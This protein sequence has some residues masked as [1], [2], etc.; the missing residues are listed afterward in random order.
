MFPLSVKTMIPRRTD[1]SIM[2][3]ILFLCDRV[4]HGVAAL[5]PSL[6]RQTKVQL[7]GH[8]QSTER[9]GLGRKC[10]DEN[11]GNAE[12]S[13]VR[14]ESWLLLRGEFVLLDIQLL[15]FRIQR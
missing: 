15:D 5:L 2:K 9:K 1:R 8:I 7:E 10:D 3:V 4:N 6:A 11:S 14:R 12:F 13:A